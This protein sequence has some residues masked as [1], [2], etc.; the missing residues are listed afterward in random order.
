M[1]VD[2]ATCPC[3]G[4]SLIAAAVYPPNATRALGEPASAVNGA[5][6]DINVTIDISNRLAVPLNLCLKASPPICNTA[7]STWMRS[8]R[9]SVYSRKT[10]TRKHTGIDENEANETRQ[11]HLTSAAKPRL[12]PS[13]F[14][15]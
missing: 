3:T 7:R 10:R 4:T 15:G 2:G 1:T 6:T 14:Q 13:P 8:I 12:V 5:R 9:V 11:R